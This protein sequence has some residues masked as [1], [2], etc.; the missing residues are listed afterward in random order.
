[1]K[2]MKYIH[3]NATTTLLKF[4]NICDISQISKHLYAYLL[5]F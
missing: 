3:L 1:M 5:M 2:N 4:V